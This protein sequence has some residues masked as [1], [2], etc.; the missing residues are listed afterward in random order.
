MKEFFER[1]WIDYTVEVDTGR[2]AL[3]ELLRDIQGWPAFTPGLRRIKALG[4]GPIDVGSRFNMVIK[5]PGYPVIVFPCKVYELNQNRME[6]GGGGWGSVIRHGFEMEALD[7]ER[8]RLRHFEY[9]T[10]LL[11]LFCLP[12]EKAAYRYDR[13]WSE[14]IRQRF[15]GVTS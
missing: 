12:F 5:I 10:G 14:A 8:T 9:A 6:W 15:A 11:A 1:T 3:F 13:G 4:R 2:A 7:E